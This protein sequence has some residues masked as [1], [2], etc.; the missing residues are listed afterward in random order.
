MTDSMNITKVIKEVQPDEIYNLA[1]M[2]R[3]SHFKNLNML[4]ILME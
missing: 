2:S 1:A 4:L 3:M